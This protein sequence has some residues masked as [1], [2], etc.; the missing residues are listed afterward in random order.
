MAKLEPAEGLKRYLNRLKK[1][2][3]YNG[4]MT[5]AQSKR[6]TSELG[7]RDGRNYSANEWQVWDELMMYASK[8]CHDR[9]GQCHEY[10]PAHWVDDDTVLVTTKTDFWAVYLIWRLPGG[11]YF[12]VRTLTAA[13]AAEVSKWNHRALRAKLGFDPKKL[14]RD[15]PTEVK[16]PKPK[17]RTAR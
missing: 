9:Y 13:E 16:E 12:G 4:T 10:A 5:Y 17:K 11:S 2:R 3:L 6:I 14:P 1:G 7:I 15:S 8:P